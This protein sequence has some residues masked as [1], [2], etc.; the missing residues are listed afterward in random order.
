MTKYGDIDIC[1]WTARWVRAPKQDIQMDEIAQ[2]GTSV[3]T[4]S[5]DCRPYRS[6]Q[7][8]KLPDSGK[9]RS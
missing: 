3:S 9:I 5:F 2:D 6:R 1:G 4:E 8:R 7:K